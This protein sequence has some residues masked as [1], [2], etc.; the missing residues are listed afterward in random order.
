MSDAL[1]GIALSFRTAKC[2]WPDESSIQAHHADLRKL[3]RGAETV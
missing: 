2:R 1:D 3:L